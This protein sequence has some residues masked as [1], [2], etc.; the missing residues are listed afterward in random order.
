[1]LMTVKRHKTMALYE[2]NLIDDSHMRL[3]KD[4]V[5]YKWTVSQPQA[6]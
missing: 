4:I 2:C 5:N 3:F 6:I 1:M